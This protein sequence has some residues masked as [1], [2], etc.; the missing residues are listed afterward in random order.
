MQVLL[1]AQDMTIFSISDIINAKNVFFC[2]ALGKVKRSYFMISLKSVPF[3]L[4]YLL[5]A[6][7]IAITI[8]P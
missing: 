1:V 6:L 7:P 8:P 5:R 3:D 2:A 4:K